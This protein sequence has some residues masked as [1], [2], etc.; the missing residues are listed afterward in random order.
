MGTGSGKKGKGRDSESQA[1]CSGR[2]GKRGQM[3]L[4]CVN[5]PD[6]QKESRRLPQNVRYRLPER[7]GTGAE[8]ECGVR[9]LPPEAQYWERERVE[10][11]PVTLA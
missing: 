5:P 4:G 8:D 9:T 7:G 6:Y 2:Q 1:K 3:E 10:A 11:G